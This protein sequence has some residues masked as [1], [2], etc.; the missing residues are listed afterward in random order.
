MW[1]QGQTNGFKWCVKHYKE[2]SKYGINGG[3][4]S[5]LWIQRECNGEIIANYDRGW[6]VQPTEITA[7]YGMEVYNMLLEKFN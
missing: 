1:T 2:G 4:I 3:R 7:A 5:K 6:D